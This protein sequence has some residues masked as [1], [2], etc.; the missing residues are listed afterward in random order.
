MTIT[1][2]AAGAGSRMAPYNEI[3]PKCLLPV[4]NRPLI[5]W[6]LDSLDPATPTRVVTDRFA[7]DIRAALPDHVEVLETGRLGGSADSLLA[8]WPGDQTIAVPGDVLVTPEDLSAFVS[9]AP[10]VPEDTVHLLLTPV[11]APERRDWIGVV[12]DG[13]R[14]SAILGHPREEATHRIVAASLPR[15]FDRWLARTPSHFPGVEVGM[16]PPEER[17]LESAIELF[18]Q[19]G[20]KLTAT[21][22]T[23]PA[24]DLDKPWHILAANESLLHRTAGALTSHDLA[25]GASIDPSAAIEGYVRLGAGSRIGANVT[26]RGSLVAGEN[27]IIDSGAILNGTVAVG[28]G[29]EVRNACF[30]EDGSVIG[31]NCVVSHAAELA[32][33]IFDGVYLYHY[34]EIYGIVGANTDI[35]AA[36]VCGSLRFDDGETTHRIKSRREI[37]STHSNASF[38]GDYCRTGVNAILLPGHRIGPYSIVGPGVVLDRDLAPRTGVRVQQE[39]TEFSWGPER[40]GW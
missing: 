20:G 35:G 6:M 24:H 26:I 30:V 25:A 22:T 19:S 17:Q 1:I 11:P 37:P 28:D 34:M 12:L 9:G 23:T 40:Y 14:V 10:S 32:G 29:S 8:L 18:R 36:T 31:R 4:L 39:L 38:I 5:G 2:I 27:V 33:V 3:R 15:D 21:I 16:M 7:T 13:E